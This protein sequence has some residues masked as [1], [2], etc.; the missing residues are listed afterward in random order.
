MIIGKATCGEILPLIY[1]LGWANL[2]VLT[3]LVGY[4]VYSQR[5][6]AKDNW[7]IANMLKKIIGEMPN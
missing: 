2:F 1:T 5:K 3:A 7:V 4:V 6:L